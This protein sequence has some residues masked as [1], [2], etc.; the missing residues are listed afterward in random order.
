[1][2]WIAAAFV[3]GAADVAPLI[4]MRTT[5][6]ALFSR[7]GGSPADIK[8]PWTPHGRIACM[9][10]NEE[11]KRWNGS[12]T[13]F[14]DFSP[15]H[16]WEALIQ[17]DASTEWGMGGFLWIPPN[18]VGFARPWSPE[19]REA[20]FV[21]TRESTGFFET[22]AVQV[23][24]ALV[25]DRCIGMRVEIDM[26]NRESARSLSSG[27]SKR[28]LLLDLVRKIWSICVRS[29]I[30]LRVCHILGVPFNPIAD[31]L[32]HNRLAEAK[33]LARRRFGSELV[34]LPGTL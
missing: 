21:T 1:M 26:D 16:S 8:V 32:S 13:L 17:I 5:G 2:N 20:A 31:A 25:A 15:F 10:W 4:H 11:F 3:Q 19:E 29:R 27:Y 18:L 33:C 6:E 24:L 9:F 28:P 7:K 14:A 30:V 22:L 23:F 34:L 12:R